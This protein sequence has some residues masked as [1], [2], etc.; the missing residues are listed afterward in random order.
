MSYR[1]AQIEAGLDDSTSM[2]GDGVRMQ[3][4]S[5]SGGQTDGTDLNS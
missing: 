5:D 1:G 4:R 2:D 3:P